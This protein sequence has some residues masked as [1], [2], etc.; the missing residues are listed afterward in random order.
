MVVEVFLLCS[1]LFSPR[2]GTVCMGY[3]DM[4]VNWLDEPG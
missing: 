4:F 3:F 2:E 1:L